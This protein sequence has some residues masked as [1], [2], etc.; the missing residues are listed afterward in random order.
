MRVELALEQR[1]DHLVCRQRTLADLTQRLEALAVVL[2]QLLDALAQTAKR[3]PVR[4]Q[5]QGIGRKSGKTLERIQKHLQWIAVGVYRPDAYIGG[6]FRQHHIAC[7]QYA[8]LGAIQC[9]VL[10]CM[11]VTHDHAPGPPTDADFGAIYEAGGEVERAFWLYE[12]A[13]RHSKTEIHALLSLADRALASGNA[14]RGLYYLDLIL[15]RWPE[16]VP[17]AFGIL[18][19]AAGDPTGRTVVAQRLARLPPW[20]SRAI[21]ELL[22][23]GSGISLVQ[24]LL[25]REGPTDVA[26]RRAEINAT[27]AALADGKAVRS[28]QA[29]F[30]ATLPPSER[31]RAGYVNDW[32]FEG[33]SGSNYFGWRAKSNGASEVTLPAPGGGLSVRFR[34]TPARLGNVTQR[35]ALPAGRYR[36]G[37]ETTTRGLEAPKRLYWRI[38]CSD[39][40]RTLGE[41]VVP[42]L[43]YARQILQTEF[44]VPADGCALQQLSIETDAKTDSWRD[45]YRGEVTFHALY[46]SRL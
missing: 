32:K 2:L 12:T 40:G 42:E 31:A 24:E 14:E 25:T 13:L 27:V 44:E 38:A 43:S 36:I 11:A 34:D 29:L 22:K 35:L 28:A 41:L 8:Q 17:R 46:I 3:Q 4:R 16:E 19:A 21:R 26:P 37:A 5:H 15:R 10:G 1:R 45:R 6:D 9:G 39:G 23:E 30:L 20:R 7:N 33:Q 18:V